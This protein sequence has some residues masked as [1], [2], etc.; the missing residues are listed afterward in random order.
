MNA[1]HS[2][3]YPFYRE[4]MVLHRCL[5]QNAQN[6]CLLWVILFRWLEDASLDKSD[7]RTFCYMLLRKTTNNKN[8]KNIW[9]VLRRRLQERRTKRIEIKHEKWSIRWPNLLWQSHFIEV[10]CFK[11]YEDINSRSTHLKKIPGLAS[12]LFVVDGPGHGYP[13]YRKVGSSFYREIWWSYHFIDGILYKMEFWQ[14]VA[15]VKGDL[16][17]INRY[18]LL[19]SDRGHSPPNRYR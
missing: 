14:D 15:P 5:R 13:F 19:H 12:N 6:S 2:G 18:K 16:S 10:S 11:W 17:G 4:H 8:K 9:M 7:W 3:A 1:S